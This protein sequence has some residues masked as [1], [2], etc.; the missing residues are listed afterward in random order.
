MYVC[1]WKACFERETWKIV[2]SWASLTT[3]RGGC[4]QSSLWRFRMLTELLLFKQKMQVDSIRFNCLIKIKYIFLYSCHWRGQWISKKC[5]NVWR[6]PLLSLPAGQLNRREVAAGPWQ[7][8]S[9][10]RDSCPKYTVGSGQWAGGRWATSRGRGARGRPPVRLTPL[11]NLRRSPGQ[12]GRQV[13]GLMVPL[14]QF[15]LLPTPP[16]LSLCPPQPS[17]C[18]LNPVQWLCILSHR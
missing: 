3:S 6:R 10:W 13:K 12:T 11:T 8:A 7:G 2:L 17:P 14:D 1:L 18:E 4:S 16:P 9:P 5:V 15:S